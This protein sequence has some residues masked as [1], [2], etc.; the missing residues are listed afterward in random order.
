[1]QNLI[2]YYNMPRK[3]SIADN[4]SKKII[5]EQVQMAINKHKF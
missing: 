5:K 1:M 3:K 2:L 4:F